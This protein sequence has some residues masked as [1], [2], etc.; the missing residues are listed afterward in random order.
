MQMIRRRTPYRMRRPSRMSQPSITLHRIETIKDSNLTVDCPVVPVSQSLDST[1]SR[2]RWYLFL[3]P[4]LRLT[5]Q[6]RTLDIPTEVHPK[7]CTHRRDV[8]GGRL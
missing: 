6:E 1:L 8:V 2:V 7:C 5:S 3:A 4:R